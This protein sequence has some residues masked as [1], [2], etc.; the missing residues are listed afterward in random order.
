MS[1]LKPYPQYKDSGV[2][3]LGEVPEHWEVFRSKYVFAERNAKADETDQQLTASQ[4]YGVIPQALYAELEGHQVVQVIL[5]R[6]ILKKT[7]INDFVISMRSFQGGLELSLYEGAVSSAYVPLFAIKNVSQGYFK[8]LFKSREFISALQQTSNLVRD[9]Q[10]LRYG[11]FTQLSLPVLEINEQAQIAA[12]L[13][14]ETGKIDALIEEQERLIELLQEK[15]QSLALQAYL[16]VYASFE[17]R[18]EN[19]VDVIY[20][21]V[22]M[23]DTSEYTALGLYNRG[24]GVFHKESALAENMGVSDFFW[25]EEGDLVISGQFAWEGAVA[26]AAKEE[27][28]TLVSHRYPLIRGKKNLI[29]TEYIYA[30]LTTQHGNFLLNEHSRGSAGRNRPLNINTLLKEKIKVPSISIQ[31][32]VADIVLLE[33]KVTQEINKVRLLLV[34]RRSALISAAVT[35]KIDVRNWQAPTEQVA[36]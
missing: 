9:G 28:G 7:K 16:D 33:R 36:S 30:L 1:E 25:V 15:R 12:F 5:G 11:N 19:L 2:E 32:E 21:L 29:L 27:A 26:M 17:D 23:D 35:G 18:L 6:D 34:E 20:R 10:A 24:R 13:D 14:H 22:V 31:K 8:Y 4:K 3:W